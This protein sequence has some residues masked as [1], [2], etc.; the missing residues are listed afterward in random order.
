MEKAVFNNLKKMKFGG[1]LLPKFA[2]WAIWDKK[3]KGKNQDIPQ[4][5]EDNVAKLKGNIVFVGLNFG[6]KKEEW[7]N[8]KDWQ[9]FHGEKRLIDLLSGTR[10][11]GAYMTDI[12]KNHHES[13]AGK[14]MSD[15]N[16][17]K[18][19]IDDNIK[20]FFKEIEALKA[21]NIE[22]YLFGED[23]ENIFK[24]YIMSHK[25]FCLFRQKV[26]KCQ[27]MQHYIRAP[28]FEK[29]APVQIGKVKPKTDDEKAWIFRPLWN[30]VA[31][32]SKPAKK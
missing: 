21:N 28:N 1:I 27:R 24:D 13:T 32:C 18:I 29:K 22:M 31:M 30:S 11:E 14:V 5:V 6:N 10:F 8:C 9:N 3:I 25:D 26:S 16:D 23:V 4:V 20:F 17:K 19:N 15:I 12:I 7:K 2:S